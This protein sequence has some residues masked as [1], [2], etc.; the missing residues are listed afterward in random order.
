M[1]TQSGIKKFK[2]S[3]K[4]IKQVEYKLP[5]FEVTQD[6]HNWR[7]EIQSTQPKMTKIRSKRTYEP[8]I[9]QGDGEK[10]LKFLIIR[11]IF[12]NQY[13]WTYSNFV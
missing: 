6:P 8:K 5:Q 2:P 7:C 12:F 3:I 13:P 4:I 10:G 11:L 1:I 9:H